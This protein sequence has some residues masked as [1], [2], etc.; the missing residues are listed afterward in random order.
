MNLHFSFLIILIA[1]FGSLLLMQPA[2][3]ETQG[4]IVAK[5]AKAANCSD[6]EDTMRDPTVAAERFVQHVNYAR[7]AL[8]MKNGSLAKEH[9]IQA[10]RMVRLLKAVTPQ[11]RQ[12]TAVESGRVIYNYDT[13]FKEHYYPIEAG[14]V[15]VKKL[16]KGPFWANKETL[17]VTDADIV[18]L[19]LDLR[20]DAAE[21]HLQ[22]AKSAIDDGRLIDADNQLATLTNAVIKVEDK[23]PLPRDVARDNISLAHNFLAARNY[24]GARF[25]LKHADSALEYLEIDDTYKMHRP[26]IVA[27]RKE[28]SKMQETIREN[29]PSLLEKADSR[30]EDWRDDIK[31][32]AS[33]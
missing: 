15:E 2:I 9:I 8:A 13:S 14:P 28:V 3:A 11:K 21:Q 17:A 23:T 18:Y 6:S 25:A 32:W 7:V 22:I 10:G 1:C 16:D 4:T 19:T 5:T 30:M 26:S 20:G 29:N 33:N 31:S 24:D 27:M 12:V